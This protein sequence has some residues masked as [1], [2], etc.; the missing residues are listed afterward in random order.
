MF[1]KGQSGNEK[2]RKPG[3]PNKT[4]EQLRQAVQVFIENN[5]EELQSN[6]DLLEPKEKLIFI[7][8]ILRFVLPTQLKTE[9]TNENG[10]DLIPMVFRI[11]YEDFSKEEENSN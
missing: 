10:K 9:L 7:E 4:T 3:I 1:K 2:G 5:I 8:K 6:F 11:L